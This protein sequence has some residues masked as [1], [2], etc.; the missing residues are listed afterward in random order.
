MP[1]NAACGVVQGSI[2]TVTPQIPTISTLRIDVPLT[3]RPGQSVKVH[4]PGDEKPR[5]FSISSSP[6]EGQFVDVTLK[7]QPNSLLEKA[8]AGVKRGA[9]ID[10]E[11][12]FG[13]MLMLPEPIPDT[14]CFIA[15]GTGVTPFRSVIKYLID[16]ETPAQLWLL[17]SVKTKA[18]LLFQPEFSDWSGSHSHFHYVPTLTQ[19]FDDNWKNETGRINEVLLRKHIQ[20]KP[21]TFMLCGPPAFVGDMEHML[22]NVMNVKPEAIRREQW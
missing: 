9:T 17:H 19:D 5:F 4:I 22:K 3:F 7:A 16:T 12:P 20:D 18:D 14:L 2:R 21:V 8:L 6:T 11:G 15:A 10:L 13:K 1:P